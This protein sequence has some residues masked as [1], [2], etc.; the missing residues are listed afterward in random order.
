M[1]FTY[2][3]SSLDS[4]LNR[5][6][7]EIGDTDSTRPLLQDEEIE[8]IIDEISDFN[9]Q[10]AKCCR[11]ICSIFA[12]EPSNIKIEGFAESYKDAFE[13]FEKLAEHYEKLGG[14]GGVPWAGSYDVDFK[15][16]TELDTTLVSPA[17]KRGMHDNT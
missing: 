2:N 7:L 16:A 5:I 8:Q 11:L 1:T 6:R 4:A 14:S 10:V 17:F 12:S 9:Q 3:V 15:D 13:H